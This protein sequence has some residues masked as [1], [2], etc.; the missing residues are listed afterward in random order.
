[1]STKTPPT[2]QWLAKQSLLHHE[3]I[4]TDALEDLP[5]HLFNELFMDAFLED[6]CKILKAMVPAWP[7][8]CL[9]FGYLLTMRK[10][11]TSQEWPEMDEPAGKTL[12]TVEAVLA[13]LDVLLAQKDHPRRCKLQVLDMR[14]WQIKFQNS[15]PP[16]LPD[17][18]LL[19]IRTSQRLEDCPGVEHRKPL[20][21]ISDL[22]DRHTIFDSVWMCVFEWVQE[23]KQL[24]HFC[25]QRLS[26]EPTCD[27]WK[28]LDVLDPTCVQELKVIDSSVETLA[29]FA[30]Y[31]GRMRNLQKLSFLGSDDS[32]IS[33]ARHAEAM[34]EFTSHLR[35]LGHLRELYM[36]W[37]DFLRDHMEQI[38]GCLEVPLVTLSITDCEL[39]ESD[40]MHLYGLPSLHH[41]KDLDLS[42]VTLTELSPEP[43]RL[44]LERVA[45]T[46]TTLDLQR[47]GI[48]DSHLSAILPALSHCSQLTTLSLFD[49]NFSM[50]L[51]KDMLGHTASLSHLSLVLYPTYTDSHNDFRDV[52]L[53]RF[54]RLCAELMDMWKALS[55]PRIAMFG[56]N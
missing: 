11:D 7:L 26:F 18:W 5:T 3:T 16:T 29:E 52:Q 54:A 1:M 31:L 14:D 23:R 32:Y 15:G 22:D 39:S 56:T 50:A 47:C 48:T 21:I 34:T 55:Q 44:L 38:F 45:S 51:L 27:F 12:Q 10:Q 25:N 9:P 46:L 4:T 49:N 42:G 24:I 30:P 6:Q 41:L 43:L 35:R 33:P 40:W 2:L 36:W 13:G 37:T 8:R 20:K 19:A 28:V 53:G 17:A